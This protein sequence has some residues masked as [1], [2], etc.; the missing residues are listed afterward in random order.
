MN[1]FRRMVKI[2]WTASRYRLDGL[3]DLKQLE[4]SDIPR[5]YLWLLRLSPIRLFPKGPYSRG[6]RLRLALETL[7]PVFIKF[8]Q[9]LST[10]R[11]L[12]PL[13]IADELARLQD[14][15]PAFPTETAIAI[16]EQALEQPIGEAF[17]QFDP[18]PLASASVAQVH[19]AIRHDGSEVVVKVVRPNIQKVIREDMHVLRT[20]AS[21][22]VKASVEARR[23]HLLEVLDDYE[24]T[25]LAELDMRQ[26]ADNTAKLRLNFAGSPMLY[27]PKVHWDY[28]R[29]NI[30]VLERIYGV[31]ISDVAQLKARGTN[32]RVLAER[33]VETFFTQVFVDNF[34]HADMHPGNIFVDVSDPESPRYIA[35][36]CAIIGKLTKEDQDYLARNLLAFFNRDYAE[37]ARLHLDSGW[38]PEDTDAG[39]F[40]RVI[41][42]LCEPIFEKP[43][44]EIQFSQFL[45]QL[46]QTASQFQMEIQPQLVLLQKTL[47]YIE[48]LGRELYPELD[49]WA[50]AKP[51]ME[52]W[53][54]EHVGPAATLREF[55]A[56]GPELLQQLPRLPALILD[57]TSQIRHLER[58]VVRQNTALKDLEQRIDKL[59]HRDRIRRYAGVALIVAATILLWGPISQSLQAT[60]DLSTVA[61][62]VSAVL[63]SLLLVRT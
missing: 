42:E 46:F 53:M 38:V 57:A 16:I 33:G 29:T 12:I 17:A 54:A 48:G 30:L 10:R 62:L 25:I 20:L 24:K 51:F 31:Q 49:L 5:R 60:E 22:L 52:T 43:L 14:R 2:C 39:E 41:R 26:E 40:E 34:F 27:V 55:A 7:G 3:V 50:T 23:L 44:H 21:L 15:V 32:M 35:V 36:D 59:S 8:G 11:D 56:R 47:L 63:G 45:V 6:K 18:A 58:T 13:D 1:P 37:V 19:T 61:G 4:N 28:C 9:L